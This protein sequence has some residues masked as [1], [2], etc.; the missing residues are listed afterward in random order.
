MFSDDN[1][2][3]IDFLELKEELEHPSEPVSPS[4]EEKSVDLLGGELNETDLLA[5]HVLRDGLIAKRASIDGIIKELRRREKDFGQELKGGDANEAGKKSWLM[6]VVR[7]WEDVLHFGVSKKLLRDI[8]KK[9][10][11]RRRN[12]TGRQTLGQ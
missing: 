5:V 8:L 3:N 4:S 6:D 1:L 10:K 11:E 7:L 2:S 9:S 12:R